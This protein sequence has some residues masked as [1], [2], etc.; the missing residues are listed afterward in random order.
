MVVPKDMFVG[1]IEKVIEKR[2]G[3]L[4]ESFGLFDIQDGE[5][6]KEA[7]KSVSY[8]ISFRAND[9]TLEDSDIQPVM[10]KILKDLSDMGIELRA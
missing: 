2:G 6:I 8:T 7:F 9:R 5:Q 10:E 3:E 1:N 4:V